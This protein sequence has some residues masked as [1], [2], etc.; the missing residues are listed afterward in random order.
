MLTLNVKIRSCLCRSFVTIVQK[1]KNGLWEAYYCNKELLWMWFMLEL[2][3]FSPFCWFITWCTTTWK[4]LSTESKWLLCI[5]WMTGLYI[6]TCLCIWCKR[7]FI[8]TIPR[9]K[10]RN[11]DV[12]YFLTTKNPGPWNNDS[13]MKVFFQ[14]IIKFGS[15][16]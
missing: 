16:K 7:D 9:I 5:S 14:V 6:M 4:P 1:I 10:M 13:Q 2:K 11:W 12:W 15:L 3:V 8:K